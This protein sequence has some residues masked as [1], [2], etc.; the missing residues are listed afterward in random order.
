MNTIELEAGP[1]LDA[2]VAR[3]CGEM[4]HA[5]H[6]LD[7]SEDEGYKTQCLVCRQW[8]YLDELPTAAGCSRPYSTDL[9][10]AFEA[11]EKCVRRW[12]D[13]HGRPM[14]EK[15]FERYHLTEFDGKWFLCENGEGAPDD[16][17]ASGPTPAVAICRAILK[18]KAAP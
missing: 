4:V 12:S 2:A 18:L 11:A 6:V 5:R 15:L 8:V 13:Y 17:I 7:P 9:N 10:A 14:S 3:T 1:K 16:P